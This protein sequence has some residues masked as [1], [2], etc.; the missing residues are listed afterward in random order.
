MHDEDESGQSLDGF[1][2]MGGTQD[3][4]PHR[5]S[6][7]GSPVGGLLFTIPSWGEAEA[8]EGETQWV[9]AP[10][11]VRWPERCL[12]C[13]GSGMGSL[14]LLIQIPGLALAQALALAHE[15]TL[16]L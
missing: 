1:G 10:V 16:L 4:G 3:S 7:G 15:G 13:W 9:Q 8:P 2:L 11:S 14:L 12:T 5:C 6:S